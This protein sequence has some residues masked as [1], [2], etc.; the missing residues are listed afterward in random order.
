[1]VTSRP[2]I[3][4]TFGVVATTHWLATTTG[5]TILEQGGNAF[6]AAVAAGIV[7]NVVEPDQ[8]GPG[9][10]MPVVL[11]SA[12]HRRVEVVCGQG[13]APAA[14][15]VG[16]LRALGLDTMPGTGH[17]PAVVPGSFGAFMLLLGAYGTMTPRQVLEP[18]IALAEGG[19]ALKRDVCGLIG[20]LLPFFA[21][22][23][24]SSAAAY[25]PDGRAPDPDGLY[26]LPAMAATYRRLI[27]EAEAAGG[28][29][30]A[31]IEAARRAWY[32]GFVAEAID[33]FLATPV[34]DT[35]G[36]AHVGLLTG[37]DLAGWRA[38]V[39]EPVSLAYGDYRLQDRAVGPGP[40]VPP[41]ARAARRGSIWRAYPEARVR[42]HRRRVRE[43]RLR[44]PRGV[45][46]RPARVGGAAR[47]A[48]LAR[49]Q[50]RAARAGRRQASVE[51]RPGR[52]GRRRADL[53]GSTVR[54][55]RRHGVDD[56]GEPTWAETR[57]P[58][59]TPCHLD[60]V[61]RYGNIVSATPS[62]GWLQSSP[63]DPRLGLAAR[64]AR[65]DVLARGGPARTSLAPRQAAAHDALAH[66]RAA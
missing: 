40:G 18:A 29:R 28:G 20:R 43:A 10:D 64:H 16:R 17:L 12:A 51:L 63:A 34:L 54:T 38:T 62:G 13:T 44:R 30:E 46:R 8:N 25:A 2:E 15:D 19:F 33:R 60:V 1:M 65:A 42:P 39:E 47:D 7:L 58:A 41:A 22:H 32:E 36:E 37:Q 52:R 31:Q 24:P 55:R 11:W 56:A 5:M 9:G 57:S 4:G 3:V 6:D 53:P 35:T 26:R 61:D 45:L 59:A 21:E 27:R 50:R 66:A 48:P 49:V 14:A 23:W